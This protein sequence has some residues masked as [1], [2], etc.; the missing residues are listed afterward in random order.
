[1]VA[2][3]LCNP[4]RVLKVNRQASLTRTGGPEMRMDGMDGEGEGGR[5]KGKVGVLEMIGGCEIAV[6]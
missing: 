1:M 6:C 2:D 5:G 3:T 4:I